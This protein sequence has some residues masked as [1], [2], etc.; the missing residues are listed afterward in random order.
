MPRTDLFGNDVGGGLKT[1]DV[2]AI[3]IRDN[4][5]LERACNRLLGLIRKDSSLLDGDSMATIDGQ[6][7]AEVVWV[8]C[9]HKLISEDKKGI[10]IAAMRKAPSQEVYSRARRELLSRDLIR[11][12][13]KAIKSGEHFRAKIAE[14]MR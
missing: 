6:L 5:V 7:F 4:P 13:S 11:V 2:P 9:F 14:A 1:E 12:S 3:R 8:D 10:F